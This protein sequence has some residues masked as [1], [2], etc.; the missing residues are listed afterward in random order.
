MFYKRR[1][2][3]GVF[4]I[5]LGTSQGVGG[6]YLD[7]GAAILSFN[8]V[9]SNGTG[10]E[11]WHFTSVPNDA[12]GLENQ[13]NYLIEILDQID[14]GVYRTFTVSGNTLTLTAKSI[15]TGSMTNS[16]NNWMR[17]KI[18]LLR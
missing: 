2:P 14:D 12:S 9:S 18:T 16:N 11:S 5:K 15:S 8:S 4:K 13:N 10:Q 17:F 1:H 3:F 7:N 6:I